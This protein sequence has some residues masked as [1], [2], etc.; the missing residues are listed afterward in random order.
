[1]D[2]RTNY[3][4]L[5]LKH[6]FMPGASPMVDSLDKVKR[7]E[8]AG[9]SAIVMHSLF[10]E[11]IQLEESAVQQHV[12]SHEETFAEAASY[13]PEA[14]DYLFGPEQYLEQ[15]VQIKQTVQVPV[16]ASLNGTTPRGWVQHAALL[17][18]A[19]ADALELNFYH[20]PTATSDDSEDVEA[21]LI[22]VVGAVVQQV[23]IPIA[24]KLSPFYSSLPN[25]V[26]RLSAAGAK[27]VVLFNRFYQPDINIEELEVAS[28]LQLS[29]SSE[30]RLRLRWLAILSASVDTS[31]AVTGGVHTPSDAIKAIMTGAHAVQLVSALLWHGPQRLSSIVRDVSEWLEKH[32]YDSL[33]QMRGSMSLRTCPDPEAFER[34][35]YLRILQSWR[36]GR[37]DTL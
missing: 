28:T 21:R 32:E 2:L 20:I 34:G 18:K 14:D 6:P 35:N 4:G 29:D 7:L 8:D 3:L 24:V 11:Q 10:E 15:V 22:E 23:K 1:M 12:V 5:E 31:Y 26:M 9:A 37:T 13:L 25:L 36:V 16:I 27:G 30:L 19:G 33:S 17:E